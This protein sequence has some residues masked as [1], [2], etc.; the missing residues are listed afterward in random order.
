MIIRDEQY[1]QF[2]EASRKSFAESTRIEM[3]KL[4]PRHSA[5]LG[6]AGMRALVSDG[7][8]RAAAYGITSESGVRLYISLML[9][10]GNQFDRDFQLPWAGR[11]LTSGG[12]SASDRAFQLNG[13]AANYLAQVA[14]EKGAYINLALEKCLDGW[15]RTIPASDAREIH[16]ETGALLAG[17]YPRKCAHLKDAGVRKLVARSIETGAAYGIHRF[18]GVTQLAALKLLLGTHCIK[19]PLFPWLPAVLNDS[20][21]HSEAERVERLQ[22]EIMRSLKAWFGER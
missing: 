11:I 20:A 18:Q 15:F 19:D 16:T 14:G 6:E 4:F 7:W 2:Q 13:A 12:I 22:E 3:A 10:L 17:L 8:N 21:I 1:Q 9:G 5:Q